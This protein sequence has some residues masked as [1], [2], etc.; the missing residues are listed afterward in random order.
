MPW[1]AS[2][3]APKIVS[4]AVGPIAFSHDGKWIASLANESDEIAIQSTS[5]VEEPARTLKLSGEYLDKRYAKRDSAQAMAFSPDGE[6]L[7]VACSYLHDK[8][9]EEESNYVSWI[10][11][12]ELSTGKVLPPLGPQDGI[13]EHMAFPATKSDYLVSISNSQLPM[14]STTILWEIA[15][16]KIAG[17]T[18]DRDMHVDALAVSPQGGWIYRAVY[19]LNN[20]STITNAHPGQILQRGAPMIYVQPLRTRAASGADARPRALLKT[21]GRIPLSLRAHALAVSPNGQWLAIANE[22]AAI[23]LWQATSPDKA[24]HVGDLLDAGYQTPVAL[25]F[26]RD[27]SELILCDGDM[28]VKR[29]DLRPWLLTAKSSTTPASPAGG[30]QAEQPP[31]DTAGLQKIVQLAED[32]LQRARDRFAAGN[33]SQTEVY[34]AEAK[35][36]EAQI[37]YAM[38]LGQQAEVIKHLTTLLDVRRQQAKG[39]DELFRRGI[40]SQ[41]RANDAQAAVLKV[42][43]R[44]RAAE[45][46]ASPATTPAEASRD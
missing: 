20:E 44:L 14:T 29:W 19:A 39:I 4:E 18:W 34:E 30:P 38:A 45:A 28:E 15:T 2:S 23:A 3:I 13:I 17:R 40:T 41:E 6:M 31:P 11:R 9:N 10:H 24:Q 12:F 32:D 16:Q 5:N 33:I 35:H 26:S 43:H 42:E 21:A 7:V 37:E 36:L 46:K 1:S 27:S 8:E 25:T 22:Q